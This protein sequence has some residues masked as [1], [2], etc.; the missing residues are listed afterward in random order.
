MLTPFL[1]LIYYIALK[2]LWVA[3]QLKNF[4]NPILVV[5]QNNEHPDKNISP[6]PD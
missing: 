6:R 1:A 3:P 2:L 5:S 4:H